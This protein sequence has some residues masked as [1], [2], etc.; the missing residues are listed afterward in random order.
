MRSKRW[1]AAALMLVIVAVGCEEAPIRV[2]SLPAPAAESPPANPPVQMRQHNWTRTN[3]RGQEEGSCVF[4]SL[5]TH[6]RWLNRPKL[7]EY[8]RANF[9]G[10]EYDSRLR[11]KLDALGVYYD[12]TVRADPRFLDWASQTRR[13]SILWW[14][15]YHC[16]TFLGWARGNDGRQYAVICDN[17][18]PTQLE[19]VERSSFA[20][21]WAGYGGF[22]LTLT[23][24]PAN[25]IP[26]RSYQRL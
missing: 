10:G 13:G 25:C 1:I 8:I 3:E 19:F 22:A 18:H 26:W 4:A 23:D 6:V 20:R 9:G 7:A 17:N 15:P 5:I 12:Y 2:Q 21:L 11:D 16:C 24:D 14:K